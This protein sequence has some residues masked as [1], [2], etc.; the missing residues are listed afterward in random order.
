MKGSA[1][2]GIILGCLFLVAIESLAVGAVIWLLWNWVVCALVTTVAPISYW[3][4]YLI[5]LA[6]SFIA[7]L[8]KTS[9]TVNR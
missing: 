3:M 9:I 6:I 2:L 5:G 1:I 4:G 8:F 7:G